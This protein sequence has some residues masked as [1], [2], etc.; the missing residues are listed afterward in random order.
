MTQDRDPVGAGH[1]R[2]EDLFL[3]DLRVDLE[4]PHHAHFAGD[5]T[6]RRP[7]PLQQA[8]PGRLLERRDWSGLHDVRLAAS[9]RPLDV[10]WAAVVVLDAKPER[11]DLEHLGIVEHP[12]LPHLSRVV[13]P[14][15]GAIG[16]SDD[17]MAFGPDANADE[18]DV[19]LR[20][21]RRARHEI[22]IGLDLAPYD[23][24]AEAKGS[25]DQ[26]ATPVLGDRIDRE[27][28]PGCIGVD[29]ALHDDRNRRL[30]GQTETVP[31]C[32]DPRT[33]QRSPAVDD[34]LEQRLLDDV[35]KRL[36]HPGKGR[37]GGVF[38]RCRRPYRDAGALAEP[39]KRLHHRR[40]N[41]VRNPCCAYDGP[42]LLRRE[43]HGARI[44]EID[45]R[46]DVEQSLPATR[47]V[48]RMKV[49]LPG[50]HE[51]RRDGQPRGGHLAE[52]RSLATSDRSIVPSERLEI[53][54]E[55]D[56]PYRHEPNAHAS[57]A[58]NLGA[59]ESLRSLRNARRSRPT[60]RE[61]CAVG[62]P[63]RT[64]CARLADESRDRQG[65]RLA[66]RMHT[67]YHLESLG[68]NHE[69]RRSRQVNEARARGYP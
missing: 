50:H 30:V 12:G 67:W 54:H 8:L 24:L 37:R 65:F 33:P 17:A 1:L 69:R 58:P 31:V 28:H 22:G 48:Q 60:R 63:A 64:S 62:A 2:D 6:G 14:G 47:D 13:D 56:C 59:S 4:L 29:H 43:L 26:H 46:D 66:R 53:A 36:V 38:S 34:S 11:S 18:L 27:H 39:T 7:E 15:L 52:V 55:L 68:G 25:L 61:L 49:R 32:D 45:P 5:D 9:Q 19:W 41:V 21:V 51:T 16:L 57:A 44:V 10:L 20:R 40:A 23:H 42:Q 35:R 3:V